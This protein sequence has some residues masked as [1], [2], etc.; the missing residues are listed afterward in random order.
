MT[1]D[2]LNALHEDAKGLQRKAAHLE[3]AASALAEVRKGPSSLSE[4]IENMLLSWDCGSDQEARKEFFGVI[5]EMRHDLL[6]I[7][8]MRLSTRA[9]KA[10]VF[11]ARKRDLIEASIGKAGKEDAA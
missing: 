3:R 11:A 8:E 9:R 5:D 6:R 7:A 4:A 10:K 2:E 1:L